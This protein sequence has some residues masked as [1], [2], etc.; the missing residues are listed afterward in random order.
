MCMI[1]SALHQESKL[2]VRLDNGAQPYHHQQ[3]FIE[4]LFWR[5]DFDL[6]IEIL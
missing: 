3:G 6:R 5:S 2:P 1:H 4:V